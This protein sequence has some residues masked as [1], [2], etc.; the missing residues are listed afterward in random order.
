MEPG[1]SDINPADQN[2]FVGLLKHNNIEPAI[3]KQATIISNPFAPATALHHPAHARRDRTNKQPGVIAIRQTVDGRP[4]GS[5][6]C[7]TCHLEQQKVDT[8]PEA[9]E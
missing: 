7:T 5:W 9:S 4:A 1:Q 2:A 6:C 3:Q 8:A